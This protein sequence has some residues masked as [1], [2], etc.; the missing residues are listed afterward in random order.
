[1][2]IGY[3]PISAS[4]EAPGDRRRFVAWARARKAPFEEARF[5]ERYDVVVV[6]ESA[7]ITLWSKYAGGKLVFDFIDSY[8]AVPRGH[9]KHRLRGLHRYLTGRNSRITLDYWGAFAEMCRRSAAVV[10]VTPEQ[11]AQIQAFCGNVHMVLD[12]HAAELHEPK[13]DYSRGEVFR[14]VW[15]GLSS[16]VPQIRT[17]ETVLRSL[18]IRR[19]LELHLV[20]DP[21]MARFLGHFGRMA[22]VDYARRI[23]PNVVVH[24]WEERTW[25]KVVR[26]FD[27]A[28]IPIDLTDPFTAGKPENKLLLFWRMGVP[29]VTSATPAYR[30]AMDAAG[31]DHYCATTGEWEHLLETLMDNE[32]ARRESGMRGRHYVE[33]VATEAQCLAGWDRVFSSVR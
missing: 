22:T 8:L 28:V 19:K 10:C 23:F 14:L 29:V 5:E 16:N 2:R 26:D 27:L 30:R 9:W 4:L 24:R 21:R 31:I 25:A 3:V 11:R 6:T 13:T 33:S 17:I 32:G 20:T 18:S 12:I 15:E 1:M 7:D